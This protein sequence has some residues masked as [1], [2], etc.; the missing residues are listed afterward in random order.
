M[1]KTSRFSRRWRSGCR[2]QSRHHSMV[3]GSSFHMMRHLV[4]AAVAA[5][6]ADPLLDMDGVVE[7]DEIGEVVH[8]GPDDGLLRGQAGPH[9]LQ[10]GTGR[11]DL[12]MTGH[13]CVR[14][15]QPRE[16]RGLH[17]GV[18][19][20]AVDAPSPARD[21][22]ARTAPAA[23]RITPHL[24]LVGRPEQQVSHDHRAQRAPRPTRRASAVTGC[25]H[26]D[27][28]SGASGSPFR[29]TTSLPISRKRA[30]KIHSGRSRIQPIIVH[31]AAS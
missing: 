12:G 11:P 25:W 22:R 8:P 6:A 30:G 17:R 13:A 3:I 4:D 9:R 31:R 19:V 24:R 18:A 2:W 29:I 1:L 16:R 5:H 28:R 7:V 10:H 27:G 23:A 21:A 26:S 14:R 20:P 15:R